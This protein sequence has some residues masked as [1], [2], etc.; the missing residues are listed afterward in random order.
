M[1][2]ASVRRET[3]WTVLAI[4]TIRKTIESLIATYCIV[5]LFRCCLESETLSRSSITL[6]FDQRPRCAV[7]LQ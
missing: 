1:A 5:T 4:V 2:H 3:N 6:A 7:E